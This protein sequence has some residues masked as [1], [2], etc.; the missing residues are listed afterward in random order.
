MSQA[1]NVHWVETS[2]DIEELFHSIVGSKRTY[3]AR[4]GNTLTGTTQVRS[5]F[6]EIASAFSMA[7][8]LTGHDRAQRRLYHIEETP[9]GFNTQGDIAL[10]RTQKPAAAHFTILK[11]EMC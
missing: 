5:T 4:V 3:E 10:S 7:F 9:I 8:P 2:K 6:P 1:D 11:P